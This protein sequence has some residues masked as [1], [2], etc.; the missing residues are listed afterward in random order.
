[1]STFWNHLHRLAQGQ[2]FNGG[3]LGPSAAAEQAAK[4]AAERDKDPCRDDP[5]RGLHHVQI[6]ALR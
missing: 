6:A 3:Y 2:L 4:A 1:M 5:N